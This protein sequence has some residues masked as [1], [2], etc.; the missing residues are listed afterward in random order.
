MN[1]SQ[2][3]SHLDDLLRLHMRLCSY[4]LTFMFIGDGGKI[5]VIF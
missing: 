4:P 3:F 2:E 1:Y 5:E